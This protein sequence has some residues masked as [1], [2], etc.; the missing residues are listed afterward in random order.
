MK[1]INLLVVFLVCSELLK[2]QN[3]PSGDDFR[4]ETSQASDIAEFSL[5]GGISSRLAQLL[6]EF[7]PRDYFIKYESYK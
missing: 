6:L 1:K 3:V 5:T 4:R 7:I 2:A